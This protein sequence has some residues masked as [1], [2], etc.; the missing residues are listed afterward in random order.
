M[1][2][3]L[4]SFV[5]VFLSITGAFKPAHCLDSMFTCVSRAPDAAKCCQCRQLTK[6]TDEENQIADPAAV[7]I[8]RYIGNAIR[9]GINIAKESKAVGLGWK[10]V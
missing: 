7:Y 1:T 6:F 8:P 9:I 5:P 10:I 3:N 4:A 2:L